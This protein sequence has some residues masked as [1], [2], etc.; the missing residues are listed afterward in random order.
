MNVATKNIDKLIKTIEA[1]EKEGM[2]WM[3]TLVTSNFGIACYAFTKLSIIKKQIKQGYI[4]LN[5][6]GI[7]D[8]KTNPIDFSDSIGN[9]YDLYA[10]MRKE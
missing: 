10:K 7:W 1:A 8:T 6:R 2:K 5:R 9:I 4:N 3:S